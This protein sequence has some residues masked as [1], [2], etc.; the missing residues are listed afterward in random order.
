MTHEQALTNTSASQ[1]NIQSLV[2]QATI[3][4]LV[5]HIQVKGNAILHSV[6]EIKATISIINVVMTHA[7]IK[8]NAQSILQQTGQGIGI[9]M[10]V[11]AVDDFNALQDGIIDGSF[12]APAFTFVDQPA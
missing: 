8:T 2:G 10:L 7:V 6:I 9:V 11:L 4:D 3:G 5:E 12:F 1:S